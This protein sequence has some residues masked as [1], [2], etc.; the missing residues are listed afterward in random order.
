MISTRIQLVDNHRI[1]LCFVCSGTPSFYLF[2]GRKAAITW[3]SSG[4]AFIARNIRDPRFVPAHK[5]EV[6]DLFMGHPAEIVFYDGRP[7]SPHDSLWESEASR[8]VWVDVTGRGKYNLRNKKGWRLHRRSIRHA[9]LGGVTNAVFTC[10]LATKHAGDGDWFIPTTGMKSTLRQV[11]DPTIGG[12]MIPIPDM[13]SGAGTVNTACGLLDWKRRFDRVKVPTVYAKDKWAERK[14]VDAE[15]ADVMD[16]PGALRKRLTPGQLVLV[17]RLAVPGKVVAALVESMVGLLHK[18]GTLDGHLPGGS[19]C[20]SARKRKSTDD[21]PGRDVKRPSVKTPTGG[22]VPAPSGDDQVMGDLLCDNGERLDAVAINLLGLNTRSSEL[23][24][25]LISTVSTTAAKADDAQ[26]PVHLFDDRIMERFKGVRDRS[27]TGCKGISWQVALT[28]L[29]QFSLRIW[30]R[31]V[32][33]EF[34]AWQEGRIY[35]DAEQRQAMLAVGWDACRRAEDAS[36]WEWDNGSTPFFWR[37]P[38]IYQQD[39]WQGVAP[40]FIGV[41][42]TSKAAQPPYDCNELRDKVTAKLQKVVDRGYISIVQD[43]AL[44]SYMYM[45]DVPKGE[46]DIRMVYDGSKSGFNDSIWAPWFALPTVETMTRTV[47]PDGWCGDRDFGEMFL[48]FILHPEARKYCGVDLSQ[49][50]LKIPSSGVA[51]NSRIL[52]LWTRNAMGL[53]SSPYL[54]V[55]SAARMKRAFLGNRRDEISNPFQWD[56]VITNLPGTPEYNASLPWIMKARTDGLIAVDLHVYIDDVRITGPTQALVWEAGSRVAKLCSFA[57]LQDAPRKLREPSQSPGAWAGSVVATLGGTVTKFVTEDRWQ[58]TQ[59]CIRWIG[60]KIGLPADKWSVELPEDEDTKRAPTGTIPHKQAERIRGFL[61]YVSR[62]YRA[63]VPY[64]KGLHLTLEMWRERR[65]E[66]GWRLMGHL[67]DQFVST[68][69]CDKAPRFV[70]IAPRLVQDI[71]TLMSLTAFDSA[72]AIDVRASSMAAAYLVGDA[73]GS[74]FG[75]CLW[76]QGETGLDIA[77]GSWDPGVGNKS[78]NFREAYNLVLRLETL[79]AEA[80]V[81]RGTELWVFTDNAV[82]ESAFN[83]G[84]SKSK[85]LHE[86]CARLRKAEMASSLH[87]HVVWIAGTRMIAQGTDGL[88]RGDLTSGVMAGDSFL[89]HIP[90]SLGAFARSEPLRKWLEDALPRNWNWLDTGADWFD[91]PFNDPKGRYVWNPPPALADVALE[92]LCEAKHVH[93]LSSH[94]FVCPVLLTG[95]WRRQCLKAA[96]VSFVAVVGSDVWP[97]ECHENV[98]IGLMCPLLDSSPWAIKRSGE[99]VDKFRRKMFALLRDSDASS[100]S[101]MRKFWHAAWDKAGSL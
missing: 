68:I 10:F 14:L 100:R 84:C 49:L 5:V 63:F 97:A 74:G 60:S 21:L 47:V 36:F 18:K 20:D 86:L 55:Q 64:L 101:H 19:S 7:P 79:L 83:K 57:G 82:A 24:G 53:R 73:S 75:D 80:A 38:E 15:L 51:A 50:K 3:V 44:A 96:D 72:P 67:D 11:T 95:R 98:F 22:L 23:K 46:S 12:R 45:F 58:K 43:E 69:A 42:P 39:I 52:G 2:V 33:A 71:Q 13:D 91:K 8:I 54:S 9:D 16:L 17:S 87:I 59:R 4:E 34:R 1:N 99:G 92:Q 30:K 61:I 88:S 65:D 56:R 78:S 37:W 81:K 76:V 40:R 41:P 6:A 48:N 66:E 25:S 93:P 70:N 94:V 89:S 27:T 32:R 77:Y 28:V 90:L 26:A 31:R 62:T 35:K 85:L 29:R